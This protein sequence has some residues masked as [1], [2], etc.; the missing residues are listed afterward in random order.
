MSAN[1]AT[2]KGN[3]TIL[4]GAAGGTTIAGI[5]VS[6]RDQFTGEMVE[7]PDEVGFTTTVVFFNDKHELEVQ[8]IVST[9]VPTLKRG[10][11]VTIAGIT[12][13]LVT[14]TEVNWEQKNARK[15]TV[16]ATNWTGLTTS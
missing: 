3:S 15:L 16:K 14:E 1:T 4:W 13:C 8:L 9:A 12:N 10:D 6:V 5:I 2:I 11:L 7:I